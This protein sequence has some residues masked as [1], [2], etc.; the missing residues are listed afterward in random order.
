MIGRGQVCRTCRTLLY[1]R[2]HAHGECHTCAQYRQ[3]HGYARPGYLF[4]AEARRCTV[5]GFETKPGQGSRCRACAQYWWIHGVERP[6]RLHDPR[7]MER[8]G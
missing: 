2:Q 8:A 4:G 1:P 6:A 3:R 7:G 5:C